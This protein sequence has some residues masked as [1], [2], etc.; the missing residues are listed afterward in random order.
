MLTPSLHR[1]MKRPHGLGALESATQVGR[2][3]AENQGPF[4][5]VFLQISDDR[6]TTA[7]FQTY[8]CPWAIACGSALT[9]VIEGKT[10][11]EAAEL[12]EADVENEVGGVSRDKKYCVKLALFALKDALKMGSENHG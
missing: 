12:D 7:R 9:T 2:F 6:I 1:H 4:M 3:G 5:C 10:L 11:Q 8:S